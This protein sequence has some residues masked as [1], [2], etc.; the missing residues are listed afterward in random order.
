MLFS[1]WCDRFARLPNHNIQKRIKMQEE[2][3]KNYKK[4]TRAGMSYF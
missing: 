3:K 1:F 4:V 2:N